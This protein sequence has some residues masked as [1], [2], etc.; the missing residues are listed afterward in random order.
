MMKNIQKS[1]QIDLIRSSLSMAVLL[2]AICPILIFPQDAQGDP[3]TLPSPK[4]TVQDHESAI[5]DLYQQILGPASGYIRPFLSIEGGYSDNIF[6]TRDNEKDDFFTIISPGLWVAM[7][8]SKEVVLNINTSNTAPG[9]LANELQRLNI[10]RKFQTYALYEADIIRYASEDQNDTI[11][12]TLEGMLFYTLPNDLRLGLIDKYIHSFDDFR[13]GLSSDGVLEKFDSNVLI[14]SADYTFNP[15]FSIEGIYSNFYL[16]YD[17]SE[18]AFRD[19]IDHT[20]ILYL[21]YDYSRKTSFFLNGEYIRSVFDTATQ[22]DADQYNLYV[23][24]Q[25]QPSGKTSVR[26]RL[27]FVNRSLDSGDVDDASEF[28]GDLQIRYDISRKTSLTL[29]GASNV[30]VPDTNNYSFMRN[31]L[32]RFGYRHKITSKKFAG[33]VAYGSWRNYQGGRQ[34]DRDDDVFRLSPYVQYNL[35][36][37]MKVRLNYTYENLDSTI[38]TKDYNSNIILLTVTF[39]L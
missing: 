28:A 12:H 10:Q 7:P 13:E 31:N 1:R 39:S 16:D 3:E 23:G 37:W 30:E 11:D 22:Y 24:L 34:D 6:N 17:R 5:E 25:W 35:R 20:G 2:A 18:K 38:N 32:L 4:S 21:N 14:L 27:G 33:I 26:T 15:K 29:L 8:Q 19:R 36:E 9:G